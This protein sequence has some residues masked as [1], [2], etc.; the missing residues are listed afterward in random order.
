MS[1]VPRC[2]YSVLFLQSILVLEYFLINII[3]ERALMVRIKLI[4]T[5]QRL[6]FVDLYWLASLKSEI[7]GDEHCLGKEVHECKVFTEVENGKF[8]SL[9]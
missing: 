2:F 1:P 6:Q 7:I 9:L 8:Q 3:V 4:L 5:M